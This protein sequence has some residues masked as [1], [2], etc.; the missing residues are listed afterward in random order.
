MMI[1]EQKSCYFYQ[2][3]T[4]AL[5]KRNVTSAQI[6]KVLLNPT[7]GSQSFDLKA[8]N[9]LLSQQLPNTDL[10]SSKNWDDARWFYEK[11][12]SHG[13]SM[14]CIND[15]RY[16]NYLRIIK[17][18]PPMLFVR[19]N[20]DIFDFL[21]GVAI[22]GAREATDAGKEIARRV[23]KYLAEHDWAVVSG[24]ALGIDA[25]AHQGCLEAKGKTIAILA[26]GLDKPSPATN[27]NLGLQILESG[28]SWISEHP[29]GVPPKKHHFVPRNRIQVGLSAGSI[30]IEAKIKSGSLTQAKFC[31]E[32]NRPLFAVVPHQIHNPLSLN[33][34]GTMHM[35]NDLNATAI[36]TKSDYLEIIQKLS[37]TKKYLEGYQLKI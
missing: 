18:A 21:P 19:G 17:D 30:I 26:G 9:L 27:A 4:L 1:N 6:K 28:G 31:V 12:K 36:A 20:K 3:L 14:R 32:Q 5:M 8:A 34:E 2:V 35:V 7:A 33:A 23:A 11:N 22:V 29:V 37:Q 24:L 16:P 25:A 10:L 15:P 13:V